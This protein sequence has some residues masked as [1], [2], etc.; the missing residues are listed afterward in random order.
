[1]AGSGMS[2]RDISD[3]AIDINTVVDESVLTFDSADRKFKARPLADSDIPAAIAR[4]AEVTAAIAAAAG[5]G[6]TATDALLK[7]WTESGAYELT[8]ITYDG[9]HTS[10]ISTATAKWPDGSAGVF[11]ATAIH[12][13]WGKV[14]AYTLTHVAS[15]KTVTQATVT[16][17]TNGN[18]TVKPALTVAAA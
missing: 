2:L 18:V 10:A 13:T 11:T 5:G 6:A 1:M 9:T 17:D 3:V 8:A 15:G 14:D 12:V 4:D 16:R 7:A